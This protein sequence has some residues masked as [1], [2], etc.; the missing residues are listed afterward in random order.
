MRAYCG[1]SNSAHFGD[2]A[3]LKDVTDVK[4]DEVAA[5]KLAVDGEVEEGK[6]PDLLGKLRPDTDGPNLLEP[7]SV[8]V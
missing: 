6:L 2:P 4:A 7:Q 3:A 1:Q 8:E 5:A